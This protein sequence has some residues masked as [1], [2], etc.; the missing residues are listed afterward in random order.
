MGSSGFLVRK[1][2][3]LHV[4]GTISQPVAIPFSAHN[5]RSDRYKPDFLALYRQAYGG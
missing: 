4:L 1:D 2:F 5:G 3:F